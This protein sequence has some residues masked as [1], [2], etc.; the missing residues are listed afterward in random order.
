MVTITSN[1]IIR[2]YEFRRSELSNLV[3]VRKSLNKF[4]HFVPRDQFRVFLIL[5]Y[6]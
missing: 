2:T 1:L 6:K 3:D 4:Q 5:F